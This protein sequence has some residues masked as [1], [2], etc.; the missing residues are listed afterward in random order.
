MR[1]FSLLTT[2]A[3]VAASALVCSELIIEIIHKVDCSRPTQ[4]GDT[5]KIHYLGTFTNGTA[6]D[7]SFG[8]E[9]LQFTLGAMKV[10]K[11]FDQGARNMCPGEIRKVTIPPD[12]GYGDKQKGPIPPNST[13]IFYTK[14]VDIVGVPKEE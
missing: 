1:L 14:L 9:P 6:F 7:S 13:L 4:E 8:G 2:V 3:V 10:I 5:L 11:G 12:L